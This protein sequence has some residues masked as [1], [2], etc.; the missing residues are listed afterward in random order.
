MSWVTTL[1]DCSS[2]DLG[3]RVHQSVFRPLSALLTSFCIVLV[4]LESCSMYCGAT[5]TAVL[6]GISFLE[7][8][9]L[10]PK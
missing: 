1:G 4:A 5:G 3:R 9:R 8:L 2:H 7:E 6:E 10:R